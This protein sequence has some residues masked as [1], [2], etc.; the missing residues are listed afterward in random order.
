MLLM[1]DRITGYWPGSGKAGLGYLRA[2]KDVNAQDWFFKAHFF[3]DPVQPGSLGIEAM[4]Q[5]IKYYML[6]VPRQTGVQPPRFLPVDIGSATEWHYRGQVTPD[7]K[8]ITVDLDILEDRVA[9]GARCVCAE[10]RLWIDGLKIYHAPR[11][12]VRMVA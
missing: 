2:E 9:D 10:A 12:G 8:R 1:L 5:L 3:Q 4:I 11:I 7:C 6:L